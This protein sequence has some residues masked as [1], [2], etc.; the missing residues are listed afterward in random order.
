MKIAII[1][2]SH[3]P[4]AQPFA[5][6]LES[7]TY[8]L[9]KQLKALGHEVHLYAA[10]G[11]DPEIL[12][13]AICK[14]TAKDLFQTRSHPVIYREDSYRDLMRKL[15]LSNYDIVHN[16]SLH[17]V[18][19]HMA[20]TLPMPM[21]S[22]LH[23]MPFIPMVNGFRHA[24]VAKNHK[25]IAISE[26]IKQQWLKVFPQM[27]SR[28]IYNGIDTRIWQYRNLSKNGRA[29]WFGRIHP[30]K[31]TH[32]AIE[33]AIKAR[34]PIDI[35]GP[36]QDQAYFD[37]KIL[38]LLDKHK[39][40]V[41]YYGALT[42]EELSKKVSKASV[43][44]CTPCWEEP[45]GLVV[46]ESLSCGTPIAG[47]KRGALPEIIDRRTGVLVEPNNTDAL[48]IAM[49]RAK[50]IFPY[51]CLQSAQQHFTI[52]RMTDQYVNFYRNAVLEQHLNQISA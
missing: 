1:A 49:Q 39:N 9:T 34:M 48:A 25:V 6:G 17:Y 30:D 44:V 35:C 3:F 18:P 26:S 37:Q 45:F 8:Y 16:N 12:H 46:A 36:I 5:G 40:A 32:L 19:L 42:N 22:M 50:L 43:C 27:Q 28:V 20:S 41:S 15:K 11:S 13:E 29:I 4:I 10:E 47:F 14:P 21:I 31:G 2:H 7:H 52:E 33:A 38:P 24:V 51:D 23:V